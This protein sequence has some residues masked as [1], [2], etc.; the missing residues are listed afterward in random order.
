MNTQPP[1]TRVKIGRSVH[2]TDQYKQA[3]TFARGL[4]YGNADRD[5]ALKAVRAA[6]RLAPEDDRPAWLGWQRALVK[7]HRIKIIS[8]PCTFTTPPSLELVAGIE[9]AF[10]DAGF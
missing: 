4:L 10:T 5:L 6:L 7:G 8:Y 2:R 1:E 9:Q 3:S